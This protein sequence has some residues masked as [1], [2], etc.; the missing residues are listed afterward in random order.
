MNAD[1]IRPR[2]RPW[3][4]WTETAG[5]IDVDPVMDPDERDGM[6]LEE[7]EQ[8]AERDRERKE[9]QEDEP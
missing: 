3:R 1:I 4:S 5:S 9:P 6:T 7:V 8:A 2:R